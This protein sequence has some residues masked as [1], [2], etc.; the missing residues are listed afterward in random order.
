MR[1]HAMDK[2][3]LWT[4]KRMCVF[5]IELETIA[6]GNR[7]SDVE[8]GIRMTDR[9]AWTRQNGS[10]Y[11]KEGITSVANARILFS[12]SSSLGSGKTMSGI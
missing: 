10:V 12:R 2:P 11:Y 1:V 9:K 7:L 6:Q 4:E 5:S 3:K 8:L